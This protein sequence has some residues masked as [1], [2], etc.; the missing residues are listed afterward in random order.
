MWPMIFN[1][2][3]AVIKGHSKISQKEKQQIQV[4]DD[5]KQE[6]KEENVND[7]V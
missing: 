4:K 6:N 7:M 1:R 5:N 2:N 3:L